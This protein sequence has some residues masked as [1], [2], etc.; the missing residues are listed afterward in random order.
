[1]FQ[2]LPSAEPRLLHVLSETLTERSWITL[3]GGKFART[4]ANVVDSGADLLCSDEFISPIETAAESRRVVTDLF[5]YAA[6]KEQGDA[7]LHVCE[8]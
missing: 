8:Q 5:E 2:P 4:L 3:E 6:V 1:M 7:G